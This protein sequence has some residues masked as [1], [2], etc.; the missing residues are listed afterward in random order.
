MHMIHVDNLKKNYFSSKKKGADVDKFAGVGTH[1]GLSFNVSKGEIFGVIGPDGAGKSTLFRI[2]AS[3][4]LP[5]SGIAL[6]DGHNVVTN[7]KSVRQIIGYMPG[8]F[9][10]Y[11]DLTVE[12]N[13]K[14]FATVFNTTIE[15][16][17]SLI[18]DIYSQ[19]EP[20]KTRRAGNLSG[21]MKQKLALSCALIHKPKVL[22]LDEPT[23]GVDPVSR[24]EFWDM[25]SRLRDQN[26]T[27]IVSTAYMDEAS[28]CDRIALML[29]GDFIAVNTP[30]G[31]ID[32]YKEELWSVQAD[33]MSG[34]LIDLRKHSTVKSC[35][36]FGDKHHITV[37]DSF[38]KENLHAYLSDKGYNDIIIDKAIPSVE[39]CFLALSEDKR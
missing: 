21:G 38:N 16:N 3:L 11:Q 10:L 26:I 32:D 24:K 35:F 12:E 1:K 34:S 27:I 17:Y 28:R 6:V 18:K 23:T 36:A 7:Y 9:S 25:L 4:L 15:E 5:E 29:D 37:S 8:R 39:D 33:N 13:L 20:F 22:I 14:F 30:Q 2:L 31:I 19:I